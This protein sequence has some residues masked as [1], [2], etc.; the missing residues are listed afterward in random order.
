MS[1]LS[2]FL[3]I[4][5]SLYIPSNITSGTAPTCNKNLIGLFLKD[6]KTKV[7]SEPSV[8]GTIDQICGR[9]FDGQENEN[10][11]CCNLDEFK[12]L[13]EQ[14]NQ[15]KIKL[16]RTRAKVKKFFDYY[17][18]LEKDEFQKL[19]DITKNQS[20]IRK[21]VG[22]SASV[23]VNEINKRSMIQMIKNLNDFFEWKIEQL[24][25]IACMVCTPLYSNYTL[26]SEVRMDLLVNVQ[27]CSADYQQYNNLDNVAYFLVHFL[28]LI[29]GYRCSRGLSIPYE[30]EQLPDLSN[31]KDIIK[32]RDNCLDP[33]KNPYQ[34][35]KCIESFQG[36]SNMLLFPQYENLN[37]M[38]EFG[39][40]EFKEF[41]GEN[42]QLVTEEKR[43]KTVT[44]DEEKVLISESISE[45]AQWD[46]KAFELYN[47]EKKWPIHLNVSCN[48]TGLK[49]TK[50]KMNMDQT[51][52]FMSVLNTSI[53]NELKAKNEELK[54]GIAD[55]YE[56]SFLNEN[57]ESSSIFKLTIILLLFSLL[58][59]N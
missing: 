22:N 8:N 15:A 10:L 31:W 17:Q 33:R 20:S 12:E 34:D 59:K 56:A 41:F 25:S 1:R 36:A 4:V 16:I 43:V 52:G 27:Q 21:C 35:P 19:V 11:Y 13:F 40:Q 24:S 23:V 3:F 37:F 58:I 54:I 49:W 38:S 45:K 30:L 28:T 9:K 29:K 26:L 44:G 18:N 7:L 53:Q 5:L 2:Q 51:S 48:Y 46:F 32:S 39:L 50:Y 14:F 57:S 42:P 6:G 47:P 55:Q